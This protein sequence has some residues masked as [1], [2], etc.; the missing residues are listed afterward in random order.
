MSGGIVGAYD[1]TLTF[2][3]GAPDAL[4]PRA[5]SVLHLVG[6][7][8]LHMGAPGTGLAAKLANNYLLAVSNVATAEAMHLGVRLGLD[9]RKLAELVNG[10]SGH[11][12]SS[13]VNNPVPGVSP[14]APAERG[15]EGGFAVPLM[16]KD[17]RL[18]QA[19]ALEVG[20]RLE[21]AKEV[22]RVYNEVEDKEGRKDFSV[23]FKWLQESERCKSS[24]S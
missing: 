12:W 3:L 14:G 18:A 5:T 4:V 22:E 6:A 1:A 7:R 21:L 10:S 24:R 8:V 2:M 9:P 11:C 15:Y 16:R 23:V 20:A 13:K 19:A 17:L